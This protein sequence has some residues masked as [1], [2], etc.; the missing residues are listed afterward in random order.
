MSSCTLGFVLQPVASHEDLLDACAVR[1]QAYG[2]HVPELGQCLAEPDALDL[3]AGTEVFLCRDKASGRAVGTMRIQ[4]SHAGPLMM[5]RS[6]ALPHWL[7]LTPRAEITRLAVGTGADP[8]TKLC[9]MKA[10]YLY[11]VAK[12]VQWMVI[13]ARNEALIRNYRRL[14]FVDAMGRDELVP[15]GHTGGLLHR[16]L[17]FDVATAERTWSAARHPLYGF[18]VQTEHPDL[19]IA[20]APL[21]QPLPGPLSWP[22]AVQLAAA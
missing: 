21:P 16:I 1:A 14:G 20:P 18:M 5:E 10:S 9:L 12:Q 19:H 17:A 4:T 2:H 3:D 22:L 7:A 8:L 13:G 15:L 6:V 11:C